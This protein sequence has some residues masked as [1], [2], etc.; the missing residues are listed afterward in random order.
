[1]ETT[2]PA[3]LAVATL[4]ELPPSIRLLAPSRSSGALTGTRR[5]VFIHC[6]QHLELLS[7]AESVLSDGTICRFQVEAKVSESTG[8]LFA[9]QNRNLT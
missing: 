3:A 9:G 7:S 8:Q 4:L 1:M 6:S 5:S 2:H